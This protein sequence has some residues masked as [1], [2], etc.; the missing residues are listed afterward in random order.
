MNEMASDMLSTRTNPQL[1]CEI[2]P[3]HEAGQFLEHSQQP[4]LQYGIDG[5]FS[6]VRI[7]VIYVSAA[8]AATNASTA[9]AASA[10]LVISWAN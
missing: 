1:R 8:A 10:A 4:I 9:A 2:F 7:H 6:V 3:M 5:E